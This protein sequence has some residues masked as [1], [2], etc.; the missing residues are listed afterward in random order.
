M[1]DLQDAVSSTD[2]AGMLLRAA[3]GKALYET[4][5]K[6]DV[7]PPPATTINAK[8]TA[9]VRGLP[10]LANALTRPTG[11]LHGFCV[12]WPSACTPSPCE[13]MIAHNKTQG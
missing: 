10:L 2:V 13:G 9:C 8:A 7:E 1:A 4:L 6:V 5:K 3:N 12:A 11:S